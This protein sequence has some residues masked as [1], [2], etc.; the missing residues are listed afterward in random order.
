MER[1]T[2]TNGDKAMTMDQA[3]AMNYGLYYA[4]GTMT[5]EKVTAQVHKHYVEDFANLILDY[6]KAYRG[7]V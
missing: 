5:L 6:F 3:R 7:I 4:K 1:N 2:T